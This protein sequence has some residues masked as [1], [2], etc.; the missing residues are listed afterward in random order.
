LTSYN[1]NDTIFP[2]DNSTIKYDDR[3]EQNVNK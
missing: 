3:D 2:S 1:F